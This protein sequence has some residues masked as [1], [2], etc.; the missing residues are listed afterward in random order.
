MIAFRA[1]IWNIGAEGQFLLGALF[2][3]AFAIY[4]PIEAP[5]FIIPMTLL[6]GTFAGAAW[7][8]I[9]GILRAK[10]GVNEV[11]TSLL[12]VYVA[13]FIVVYAIRQPMR[14]P[15]YFLPMSMLVC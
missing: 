11:I 1:K 9:V 7:G 8:W 10:W 15:E 5:M 4:S 6:V 3:G 14:D 12:M 2:G 13:G